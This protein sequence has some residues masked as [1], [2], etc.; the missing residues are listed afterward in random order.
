M[1]GPYEIRLGAS[2]FR[3]GIRVVLAPPC[4]GDGYEQVNVIGL[5]RYF[6]KYKKSVIHRNLITNFRIKNNGRRRE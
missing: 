4:Q 1:M 3:G 6:R 5:S 2:K